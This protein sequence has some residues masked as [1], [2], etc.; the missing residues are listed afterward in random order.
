MVGSPSWSGPV[1]GESTPYFPLYIVA[2]VVVELVALRIP[3]DR[4]LMFGLASGVAIGT[5][6]LAA[7]W[8]W[9]HVFMPIAWPAE[10]LPEGAVFGFAMAVAG[11]VI[12]AWI[13]ARLSADSIPRTPP[14]RVAGAVAAA[15]VAGMVGIA[16]LKPADEGVSGRVALEQTEGGPERTASATV[17]LTRP[18]PPT[19]PSGSR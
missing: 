10:L 19:G 11:A 5:F 16:T 3:R 9:S 1:L 13:G 8:G 14:L 2:A 18:T 17:T 4:P 12:G 7:E 15:A 6:G